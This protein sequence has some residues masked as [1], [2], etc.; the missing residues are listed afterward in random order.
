MTTPPLSEQ[1]LAEIEARAKAATHGPWEADGRHV[2]APPPPHAG[3]GYDEILFTASDETSE[4]DI[5][6]A[7]AAPADIG[8]LLA[9]VRRLRA[10]LASAPEIVRAWAPNRLARHK[11]PLLMGRAEGEQAAYAQIAT[12]LE[13]RLK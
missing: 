1:Y 11:N 4:E 9:E 12:L 7:S 2:C 5:A 10:V 6:L 3:T 13:T 8:A